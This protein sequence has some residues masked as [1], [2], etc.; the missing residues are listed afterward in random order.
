MKMSP[1]EVDALDTLRRCSSLPE[2]RES[3]QLSISLPVDTEEGKSLQLCMS[4][5][6][7]INPS[8]KGLSSP[9]DTFDSKFDKFEELRCENAALA[10]GAGRSRI[11]RKSRLVRDPSSHCPRVEEGAGCFVAPG[12]WVEAF[13]KPSEFTVEYDGFRRDGGVVYYRVYVICCGVKGMKKGGGLA[14]AKKGSQVVRYRRL[15]SRRYSEYQSLARDLHLALPGCDVLG[16]LPTGRRLITSDKSLATRGRALFDFLLHVLSTRG[17]GFSGLVEVTHQQSG[18]AT[19]P[20]GRAIEPI[21][22]WPVIRDFLKL[23]PL[24]RASVTSTGVPALKGMDIHLGFATY[25]GRRRG[26]KQKLPPIVAKGVEAAGRQAVGAVGLCNT[27]CLPDLWRYGQT[28]GSGSDT[29]SLSSTAQDSFTIDVADCRIIR[30]GKSAKESH[31]VYTLMIMCSGK[32]GSP[33]SRHFID[34]RYSEF[35]ALKKSLQ[36]QH[37][38]DEALEEV[39][40]LFP[41]RTLTRC[42]EPH[43]LVY[44]GQ[45]LL[46]FLHRLLRVAVMRTTEAAD[47]G[48]G[49]IVS[50]NERVS[51]SSLPQV[52]LFLKLPLNGQR[53]TRLLVKK[54]SSGVATIAA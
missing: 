46:A 24:C 41:S 10:T 42:L 20:S 16:R 37:P 25:P 43:F 6:I 53:R 38:S 33:P 14:A 45:Q 17:W 12:K 28:M 51:V 54:F 48:V 1:P 50:Y 3:Q 22:H 9:T 32:D 29:Y 30:R 47:P 7:M 4:A 39:A 44:R 31:A 49:K 11:G 8:S 26:R 19:L 27:F 35:L 40:R 15:V 2:D 13:L 18:E 23:P 36:A 52:R 34:R 21:S 5:P